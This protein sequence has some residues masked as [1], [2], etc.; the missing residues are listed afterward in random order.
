M[1]AMDLVCTIPEIDARKVA[2]AGHS[3]LGW[4]SVIA[5]AYDERFA[6]CCP[7]AG[8]SK[9]ITLVP[10]LLW[11]AWFTPELTNWTSVA[12]CN[13]SPAAA[14]KQRGGKPL[15]PFEQASLIG[16]IAPRALHIG[17]STRDASAPPG[18]CFGTAKS[19]EPVYRLFGGTNFPDKSRMLAEKPFFGD[20][21]WHCKKGDHSLTREDWAA[22]IADA[23]RIFQMERQK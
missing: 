11:P 18:I 6:L 13:M 23:R 8:G 7:N 14:E 21:S 10:N 5:S 1:R 3:R 19:V 17:T 15:P 4:A 16:C 22:Y 9:P 20:I 2:V 12:K